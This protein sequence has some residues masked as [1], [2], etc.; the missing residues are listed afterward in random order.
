M[1]RSRAFAGKGAYTVLG[2]LLNFL[3]ALYYGPVMCP[4]MTVHHHLNKSRPFCSSD[5][6]ILTFLGI[7]GLSDKY[8]FEDFFVG[9]LIKPVRFNNGG[10][11]LIVSFAKSWQSIMTILM[12]VTDRR[13]LI[14]WL[15]RS[16]FCMK[17]L[18]TKTELLN[19]S[20][21]RKN[22]IRNVI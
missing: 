6:T 4:R 18:H 11:N 14:D 12:C 10:W 2:A 21:S 20:V 17:Y 1:E 19:M 5:G 22:I 8:R 13:C 3:L 15:T 7:D 16:T 9:K